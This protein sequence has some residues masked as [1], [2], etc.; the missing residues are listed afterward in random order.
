MLHMYMGNDIVYSIV[1]TYGQ[2][3]SVLLVYGND[4]VVLYS[5]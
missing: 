3:Y 5:M 4:T 1:S 2:Y